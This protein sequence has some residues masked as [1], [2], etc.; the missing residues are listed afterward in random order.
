[1]AHRSPVRSFA[2]IADLDAEVLI[3]GSM[4]GV[5]SLAAGCY[6][7]HP[8]NLF[9]PIMAAVL[10]FDPAV[11]YESRLA[12]VVA[13]RIALW[14]V[15]RSCIRAGSLDASIERALPNDFARFLRTHG[16]I[17][18]VFFNGAKAEA[19]YSRLVLPSVAS[20]SIAYARLPSTSPANAAH[21]FERRLQ[22]W[23]AVCG[24]VSGD[25]VS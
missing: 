9:W 8:R 12:H 2:P 1:L 24:R 10:G 22:A 5:A 15:L 25:A 4:P 13:A 18:R 6:Y 7:A 23:R 19:L 17:R 16:R 20:C 14:D 3:L 21:P 11:A